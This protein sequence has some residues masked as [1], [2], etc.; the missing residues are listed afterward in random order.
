MVVAELVGRQAETEEDRA[1]TV[2]SRLRCSVR[3]LTIRRADARG[4]SLPA[5]RAL[6]HG[7]AGGRVDGDKF[8]ISLE[9]AAVQ[10]PGRKA[11]IRDGQR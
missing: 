2:V 1:A 10:R 9:E 3:V 5:L 11:G 4:Y 8:D 6:L 7:P